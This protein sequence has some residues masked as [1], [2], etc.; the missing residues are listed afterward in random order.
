MKV[1]KTYKLESGILTVQTK[2][3]HKLSDVELFI[4]HSIINQGYYKTQFVNNCSQEA[5]EESN[6]MT[7][8]EILGLVYNDEDAFVYTVR[9]N[10]IDTIKSLLEIK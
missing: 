5:K 1:D 8:L 4:L 2:M 10:D 9:P 6:A 3:E 7:N